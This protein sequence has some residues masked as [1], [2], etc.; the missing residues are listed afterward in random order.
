MKLHILTLALIV[1]TS[2]GITSARTHD[3]KTNGVAATI[4]KIH[5]NAKTKKEL[6]PLIL[7]Y[8]DRIK[9]GQFNIDV[10]DLQLLSDEIAKITCKESKYQI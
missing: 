10:T 7:K 2:F 3:L 9:N 1:L 4:E 6:H 5:A 8:H